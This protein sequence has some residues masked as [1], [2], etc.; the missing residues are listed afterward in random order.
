[1][2]GRTIADPLGV[3][4]AAGSSGGLGLLEIYTTLERTKTLRRVEG[5]L[6]PGGESVRGYEIHMGVSRGAALERPLVQLADRADGARS[7]DDQI[8]ATYLHGLFDEGS[9]CAALLAWAGLEDARPVD[10]I[11]RRERDIDRLADA[12]EAHLDVPQLLRLCK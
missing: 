11:A 8:R 9:A 3:E 5:E 7:A 2:L 12:V 1:M 10:Y 4:G 6:L